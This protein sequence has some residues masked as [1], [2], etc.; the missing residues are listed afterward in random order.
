MPEYQTT[1]KAGV[2]VRITTAD[3]MLERVSRSELIQQVYGVDSSVW[4]DMLSESGGADYEIDVGDYELIFDTFPQGYLLA[5]VGDDLAGF[6]ETQIIDYPQDM[7]GDPS[8]VAFTNNARLIGTHRPDGNALYDVAFTVHPD[9]QSQGIGKVLLLASLTLRDELGLEWFLAGAR[10]PG[11]HLQEDGT[12]IDD[13]LA[14]KSDPH[15]ERFR[16][17]GLEVIRPLK[18]Y[19]PDPESRDWGVLVGARRDARV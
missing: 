18:D 1:T 14:L 4:A 2:E 5:Y 17:V 7:E 10:C 12:S 13:Y 15:V 9:W 3:R 16:S 8:W 6:N 11:F 19:M